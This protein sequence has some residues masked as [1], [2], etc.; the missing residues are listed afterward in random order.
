LNI[1]PDQMQS[2]TP[3][4]LLRRATRFGGGGGDGGHSTRRTEG[5]NLR[6]CN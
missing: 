3:R 6:T 1:K 4:G 2:G 5:E